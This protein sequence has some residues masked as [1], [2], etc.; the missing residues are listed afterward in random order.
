MIY[1]KLN[2]FIALPHTDDVI[3]LIYRQSPENKTDNVTS[4]HIH[5]NMCR[6]LTTCDTTLAFTPFSLVPG[7]PKVKQRVMKPNK[8]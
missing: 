7:H 2:F 8:L 3:A 4:T 5:Y 6:T 1:S